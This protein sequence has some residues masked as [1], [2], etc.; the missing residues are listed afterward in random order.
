MY[1]NK[2]KEKYNH[3]FINRSRRYDYTRRE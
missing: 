2:R 3:K 1:A